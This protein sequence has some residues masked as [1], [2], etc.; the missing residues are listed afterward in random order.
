MEETDAPIRLACLVGLSCRGGAD[1]SVGESGSSIRDR[2]AR[3]V[4]SIYGSLAC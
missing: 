3:A 2:W 4:N 1:L